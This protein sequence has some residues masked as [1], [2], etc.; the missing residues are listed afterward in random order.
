MRLSYIGVF[1]L[2]VMLTVFHSYDFECQNTFGKPL[3]CLSV[4]SPLVFFLVVLDI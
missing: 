2:V 4:F 3:L 1:A